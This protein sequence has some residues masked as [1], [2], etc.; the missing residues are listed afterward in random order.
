MHCSR[1]R[2]L[3]APPMLLTNIWDHA[4]LTCHWLQGCMGLLDRL[5]LPT[6]SFTRARCSFSSWLSAALRPALSRLASASLVS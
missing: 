4:G 5:Y 3:T 6:C 2:F 1:G